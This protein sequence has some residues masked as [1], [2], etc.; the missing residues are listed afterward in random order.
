M[1]THTKVVGDRTEAHVLAS[2]L[3]HFEIVLL[4]FGENH[5]Y[6]MLIDDDGR[7]MRV[8][9]KTG[10]LVNGCVIFSTCSYTYHHPSNRGSRP[11]KH[12]YRG[13]ADL[14]GVYCRELDAVY[15]IPVDDVGVNQGSLRVTHARNAQQRG[16]RWAGDYELP[17]KSVRDETAR[18]R[19]V[20]GPSGSTLFEAPAAYDLLEPGRGLEP[21]QTR[22]Q[23][24]GSAN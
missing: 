11:Y 14:F 1:P 5:R 15:L 24:V 4:P 9:C 23:I 16:I 2:L 20:R 13:Q 10:R 6:D 18:S 3:D 7:F 22:L 8:Q 19:G 21:L 17:K 12:D